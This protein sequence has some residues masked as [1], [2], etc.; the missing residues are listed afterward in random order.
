LAK[1]SISPTQVATLLEEIEGATEAPHILVIDDEQQSADDL[2]RVFSERSTR[3]DGISFRVESITSPSD[4]AP[5]LASDR[6]DIY[7]VDLK[8]KQHGSDVEDKELGSALVRKI[9][10]TSNAGIIVY[11]TEPLDQTVES[12]FDGADDYI[13]KGTPKAIIRSRVVALWRR[14]KPT[15]PSLSEAYVHNKRTFLVGSWRFEIGSRE[16]LND[17]GQTVR[18]SPIEHAF[19]SHMLTVEGHEIDKENFNVYILGRETYHDDRRIDNLVF[20]LRKKLGDTVQ[21][22]ANRGGGYKLINAKEV[23]KR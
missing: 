5:Y 2:K 20:R 11:S 16:L 10:E 18:I 23:A 17:N 12:L 14:I 13:A 3:P 9:A 22:I 15:R 8:F 4:L 6:I 1:S 7:I 19:L 21:F